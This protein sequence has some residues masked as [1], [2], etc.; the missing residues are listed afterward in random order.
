MADLLRHLNHTEFCNDRSPRRL[1]KRADMRSVGSEARRRLLMEFLMPHLRVRSGSV[2]HK[3]PEP[4]DPHARSVWR[5]RY[6]LGL[7]LF[8]LL[9]GVISAPIT[10]VLLRRW[11][12]SFHRAQWRRQVRAMRTDGQPLQRLR[13]RPTFTLMRIRYQALAT[14]CQ[15][16][17]A[18]MPARVVVGTLRGTQFDGETL[19]AICTLAQV[20]EV[21]LIIAVMLGFLRAVRRQEGKLWYDSSEVS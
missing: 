6:T 3:W 16:L 10:L 4:D 2:V 15:L 12:R 5:R 18:L 8:L 1:A 20:T 19:I 9:P 13:Q 14:A 7:I 21:L 11:L 17:M